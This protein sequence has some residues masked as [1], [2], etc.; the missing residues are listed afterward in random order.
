MVELTRTTDI[1]GERLRAIQQAALAEPWGELLDCALGG[2]PPL[3]VAL[4]D[5]PAGYAIVMPGPEETVYLTELAVA[6]DEQ[7]QGYGSQ[8]L[9]YLCRDQ[10]EEGYDRL[11][12]TVRVVDDRAREFYDSHAF[13]V[14]ERLPEEYDSG[15]GLLLVRDL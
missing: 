8:L 5:E 4:D 12:L 13:T 1:D 7:G 15:D 6:P 9:E 14:E 2:F 11:A 10:R 3:Y